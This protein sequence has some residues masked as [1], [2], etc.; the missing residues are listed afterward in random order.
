M[1]A[2]VPTA[3]SSESA[4]VT[5]SALHVSFSLPLGY[6]VASVLNAFEASRGSVP[7]FTV[8]RASLERER[9]FVALVKDIAAAA[10]AT[11]A[12][13]FAPG[14]TLTLAGVSSADAERSDAALAGG[15]ERFTANGGQTGTRYRRVQGAQTY[16]SA[17]L[18]LPDGSRLVIVMTYAAENPAFDEHAYGRVL[19]SL[20]YVGEA[21]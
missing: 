5:V 21:R 1:D 7:S 19:A 8:T 18:T 9:A 2:G 10:A 15:Q 13:A 4:P 16:D 14:M 17:Y 11:E 3:P 6:R 12:P 20:R